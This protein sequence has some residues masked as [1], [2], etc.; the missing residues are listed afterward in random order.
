MMADFYYLHIL[1]VNYYAHNISEFN[2]TL[3]K[4][5]PV[6]LERKQ[7]LIILLQVVVIRLGTQV[8]LLC[9]GETLL[10]NERKS[11]LYQFWM[12]INS[13]L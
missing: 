2:C 10:E 13:R 4:R 8:F 7:S 1:M 5:S 9:L 12:K 3:N 11:Y 6:K